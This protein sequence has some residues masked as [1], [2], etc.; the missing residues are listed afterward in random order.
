[1]EPAIAIDEQRV[2]FGSSE[3]LSMLRPGEIDLVVTSPPYWNLKDYGHPDEI[4]PSAYDAYLERLG[5][6]WRQC[7]EACADDAVLVVNVGNRRHNRRFYPLAFDI[8]NTIEG[9]TLWDI[10]IWYV[11]NALPQPNHYLERL[12]DNK[13]EFVLVFT[14]DGRTDYTFH[15]P[16]VPQKYAVADPRAHKRNPRGRC[17]GNVIRIPAYRPPNVKSLG[18]HVAAFPEELVALVLE[19]F[20]DLGDAVLDPFLGSGTTLKV[21]RAMGRR[22]TGVELNRDY[23]ELIRGRILEPWEPPDWRDL[24]ILHSASMTPG[25]AKPR[26]VHHLR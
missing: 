18:Y 23:E 24:D 26:K 10:V 1:V 9:W 15:K 22:G 7:Y 6:V 20:S 17:I 25:A 5:A 14:K 8:A 2:F 12:F 21:A 16:R 4:G 11:P 3:D 19:S 13:F